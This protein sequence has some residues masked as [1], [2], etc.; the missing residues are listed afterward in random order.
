MIIPFKNTK[1]YKK[2]PLEVGLQL[3]RSKRPDEKPFLPVLVKG[4]LRELN[5]QT[6]CLHLHS[7]SVDELDD[8]S[9]LELSD[10]RKVILSRI[11]EL[12]ERKQD[13]FCAFLVTAP[14]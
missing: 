14:N 10:I 7:L 1:K 9:E 3:I 6:P 5:T 12:A 11:E 2:V 4:D 8:L 13:W